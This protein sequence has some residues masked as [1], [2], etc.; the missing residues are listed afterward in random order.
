MTKEG[1]PI[2]FSD[3]EVNLNRSRRE[4]REIKEAIFRRASEEDLARLTDHQ[5]SAL[6]LIFPPEGKGLTLQRTA[7]EFGGVSREAIRQTRDRAIG[8]LE[9]LQRG[10]PS[11]KKRG[12]PELEM[13]SNTKELLFQNGHL[14]M[15]ELSKL[16][17]HSRVVVNRFKDQLDLPRNPEGRLK[18]EMNPEIEAK[19]LQNRHLSADAH[20]KMVGHGIKV[21]V[22]WRTELGIGRNPRGHPRKSGVSS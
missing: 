1:N 13:D 3:L 14:P 7:E 11:T 19:L 17:R 6:N 20:R 16:V 15:A 21:V 22:R 2:L 5:L 8:K 4:T 10:E 18:I 12:I 9:R